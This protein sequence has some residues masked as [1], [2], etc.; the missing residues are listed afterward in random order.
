[1]LF[2][3]PFCAVG[4]FMAVRTLL[5]LVKGSTDWEQIILSAVFSLLFGG[6]GFGL[7]FVGFKAKKDH[8]REEE[9]KRRHPDTPW[10]WRQDWADGRIRSSS[11]KHMAMAWALAAFVLFI[12]IPLVPAV[13][14]EAEKGGEAALL[15]LVFPL[16]GL[17]LL[18]WAIRATI[19][20]RRFGKT[21]RLVIEG[22]EARVK[23]GILG[24]GRTRRFA[25]EEIKD[26]GTKITMQ[27][28]GG[29]GTPYYEIRLVPH[30]GR[31]VTVGRFIRNKRELDWL[32][33]EIKDGLGLPVKSA[34][35]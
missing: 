15:G 8:D 32:V 1:M 19:R 12:S 26:I 34:A 10:L 3:L 33:G 14:E 17:G 31:P 6:V 4:V 35:R 25:L 5:E 2:L 23:G 18:I 27:H 22:N 24:L 16:A 20:W 28:G 29:S 7:L 21:S 11:K 30:A 9:L 13:I